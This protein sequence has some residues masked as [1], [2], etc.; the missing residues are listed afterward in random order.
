[1]KNSQTNPEKQVID[2]NLDYWTN[3]V[4]YFEHAIE[5]LKTTFA[6]MNSLL[7]HSKIEMEKLI[8]NPEDI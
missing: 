8:P 7:E 4:E 3:E 6:V 5:G 1:M 2:R